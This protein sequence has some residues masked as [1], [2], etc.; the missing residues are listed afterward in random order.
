MTYSEWRTL[1]GRIAFSERE[2]S[3]CPVF[4]HVVKEGGR[5]V[6]IPQG[7]NNPLVDG[8]C[9]LS[10]EEALITVRMILDAVRSP[11]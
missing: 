7:W 8:K 11:G 5:W 10:E 1:D 3:P 9:F 6:V 4:A 2:D